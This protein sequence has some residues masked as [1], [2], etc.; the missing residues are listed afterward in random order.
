[1]VF[2]V[3]RTKT[4]LEAELKKVQEI[5]RLIDFKFK[6]NKKERECK[7]P[8]RENG[9]KPKNGKTSVKAEP[10]LLFESHSMKGILYTIRKCYHSLQIRQ[11][12]QI[13]VCILMCVL[14]KERYK[15]SKTRTDWV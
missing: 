6:N 13:C 1:M 10:N 5:C 12:F 7:K 3:S 14:M 15:A 4:K 9:W 8:E 11:S 2:K